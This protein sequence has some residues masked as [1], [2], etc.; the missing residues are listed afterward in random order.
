MSEQHF[1]SIV[2]W[3]SSG[4]MRGNDVNCAYR[5]TRESARKKVFLTKGQN[6]ST[7]TLSG[8][9]FRL[10]R[11]VSSRVHSGSVL[12]SSVWSPQ[13]TKVH[14]VCSNSI[15]WQRNQG[16]RG[17]MGHG[18]GREKSQWQVILSSSANGKLICTTWTTKSRFKPFALPGNLK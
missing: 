11:S 7:P 5:S 18:C 8:V 1:T 14:T 2:F 17:T 4:S 6:E 16:S 9:T 12:R 3:G 10:E 13:P 15:S